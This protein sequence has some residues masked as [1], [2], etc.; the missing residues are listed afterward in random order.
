MF[1]TLEYNMIMNQELVPLTIDFADGSEAN[2]TAAEIYQMIFNGKKKWIL[3]ANGTIFKSDSAG[4]I[5]GMLTQW[6]KERQ[7]LQKEYKK[8]AKLA[9]SE[10]DPEKKKTLR[11]QA[12]FYDLSQRL[13]KVSLNATYGSLGNAGSRW[14]DARVAQSV[15]LSGRCVAK[16]MQ[17]KI[18]EILTG[19]YNHLGDAVIYGDTD[20]IDKDSVI[21]TSIG[22]RTVEELFFS[23]EIFWKEGDK[24]YSR[25]NN[26]KVA[27]FFPE[28]EQAAL[29]KYNYVYRHKTS[30]KKFK[31]TTSNG[32]QVI[33]TDDHSVMI[34]NS[35]GKLIEKKPSEIIVGDKIISIVSR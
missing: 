21:M 14:F 33:V 30:K 18:N 19:D 1:G 9:A 22:D 8:Y 15:T 6:Y 31:V 28:L 4:I 34:I 23:G 25:N 5:A 32:N 17:A 11:A 24:E 35:D 12:E 13:R 3:S 20:S 29:T 2:A 27:G 7:A 10:L 16:H 26:I